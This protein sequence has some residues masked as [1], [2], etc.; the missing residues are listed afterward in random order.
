MMVIT[1]VTTQ[2]PTSSAGELVVRPIS[3]STIKTP[4][5]IIEPTTIA[6]ELKSPSDC[7]ICGAL[8]TEASSFG[9]TVGVVTWIVFTRIA[10]KS[11]ALSFR[12]I[13]MQPS[14]A[15]TPPPGRQFGRWPQQPPQRPRPPQESQEQSPA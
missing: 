8:E 15:E 9:D 2:A 6:V 13:A 7:T 14:S 3:A 11:L 4:V 5:P 1:A 12:P 10:T